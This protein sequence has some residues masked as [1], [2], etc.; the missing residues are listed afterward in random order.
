[1]VRFD[2]GQGEIGI[3]LDQMLATLLRLGGPPLLAALLVGVAMSVI[4]AVTQIHE[5]TV[6]FVPK[7]I[8]VMATVLLLGP[9]MYESLNGFARML[10]DRIVASGTP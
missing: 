2:M 4:Q 7:L 10:F 1:M 3:L 8:A 5:Q 9:Y 6:V